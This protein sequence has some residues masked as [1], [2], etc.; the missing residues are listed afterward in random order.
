[1]QLNALVRVDEVDDQ[2]AD[3]KQKDQ[4]DQHA[5]GHRLP[6]DQLARPVLKLSFVIH[7]KERRHALASVIQPICTCS[8]FDR[9]TSGFA[10]TEIEPPVL[11]YAPPFPMAAFEWSVVGTSSRSGGWQQRCVMI[12]QTTT[13]SMETQNVTMLK[14][15]P[16]IR[17]RKRVRHLESRKHQYLNE[18]D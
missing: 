11:P 18:S 9:P 14:G 4:D 6:A 17:R 15:N 16:M 10:L 5:A 13:S 7:S 3:R 12:L 1:M 2:R 8:S